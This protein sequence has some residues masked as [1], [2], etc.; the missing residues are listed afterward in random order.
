[1]I[2][3][4]RLRADAP[5]LAALRADDPARVAAWSHANGCPGC[6]S[7][8]RE[9]ERLQ[10]LIAGCEPA[11]L[12]VDAAGRASR[13]IVAELRRE[14]RRRALG[15]IAAICASMLL[16]VGF[17]RSRSR[18]TTRTQLTRCPASTRCR[19]AWSARTFTC[20]AHPSTTAASAAR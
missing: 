17:A 5:G 13:A 4:D 14:A 1:M 18:S 8:L 6:A 12:P 7:A 16:F 19:L 9:A 11:P 10:A 2:D 15:S 20:S 3:C